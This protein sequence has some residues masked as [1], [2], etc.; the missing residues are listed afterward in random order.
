M[1]SALGVSYMHY[2]QFVKTVSMISERDLEHKTVSR[3]QTPL[4]PCIVLHKSHACVAVLK[5][6]SNKKLFSYRQLDAAFAAPRKERKGI[7]Q[8]FH[9]DCVRIENNA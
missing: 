5:K 9:E 3:S 2:D 1:T 6:H 4:F 7:A 8:K